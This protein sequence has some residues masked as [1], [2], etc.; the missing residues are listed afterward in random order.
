MKP[1]LKISLKRLRW[2]LIW[3]CFRSFQTHMVY[4]IMT[5]CAFFKNVL[6]KRHFFDIFDNKNVEKTAFF[7]HILENAQ[8]VMISYDHMRLKTSKARPD[9]FPSQMVW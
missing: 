6:E 2:E 4:D 3:T 9:K 5:N 7:E 1:I 8:L